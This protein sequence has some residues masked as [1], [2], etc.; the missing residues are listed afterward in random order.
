VHQGGHRHRGAARVAVLAAMALLTVAI[1]GPASALAAPS[2]VLAWGFNG[3]GQLGDGAI[4]GPEE[5]PLSIFGSGFERAPC[6]RI[7]VPVSG[8]SG[9]TSIAAAGPGEHGVHGHSLALLSN[10]TVVAWGSNV[11]GELGDGVEGEP[12]DVPVP[13]SGLSGV[14]A[15][16]AGEGHSL[17]LLSDGTVAAWGEN[18]AGQLGDGSRGEPSDVPV[19]V[20]GLSGVTAVAAGERDSLALLSDGTV[21][22]WGENQ[23]GELGDG[24][25]GEP[26][27]V[28]VPVSG[29]SGVTAIAAGGRSNLAL[30]GDGTV[31]AWGSGTDVPVPVSGLTGVT[32]IASGGDFCLA[33][34]SNGTVMAWGENIGGAL[35]DGG[36][37]NENAVV[38]VQVSGLT[39]VMAV[40]AG[41]HDGLA[42]L[43]N[44]TVMAW[45]ENEFGQLGDG[46]TTRS[47]VPVPVSSLGGATA[48][49]DAGEHSL[50]VSAL[51]SVTAV[52]PNA[53]PFTGGTPVSITGTNFTGATAVRFG[54]ASAVRITLHSA[55]SITA[56]SPPGKGTVDVTVTS[57]AG[58]SPTRVADRF[59]YEP[60]V[61]GVQPNN[62]PTN[63]RPVVTITGKDLAGATAVRFGSANAVG[64]RVTSASSIAAVPPAGTGTVNVTVT[65]PGGTSALSTAD[66]F[67]Y[68]TPREW[69]IFPTPSLG[70][71]EN[72]LA[73]ISCVSVRFCVAVGHSGVGTAETLIEVWNGSAWSTGAAPPTPTFMSATEL[74]AVSCV[75]VNFCVAVGT[76]RDQG[77][78]PDSSGPRAL[79][80][81]WNGTTWS[82]HVGAIKGEPEDDR[83]TLNGVS[84]VSSSFCLAV[85]SFGNGPLETA[86]GSW[87][88]E[89]WKYLP[90]PRTLGFPN[91]ELTSVSCVSPT[92][93]MAV[94]WADEG[95]KGVRTPVTQSWNGSEVSVVPSPMRGSG[96]D[97]LNG[98]S[99]V[100]AEDCVAVGVAE[101]PLIENWNGST[102]SIAK[103]S[104]PQGMEANAVSCVSAGSCT[105]VG[106]DVPSEKA[107]SQTLVG[108]SKGGVWSIVSSANG[109][110]GASAL[111]GVSC[112]PAAPGWKPCFAVG[113]DE[114]SA[115]GPLQALVELG[116]I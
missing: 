43:S 66:Q 10:G 90:R 93:C 21:V 77:A 52:Q 14:T 23:A 72:R 54:S 60:V 100:S 24:V 75:S 110:A 58:T 9:V 108:V 70:A 51:P 104:H 114:A 71:V 113:S 76:W 116:E 16:A 87:N 34:L 95:F 99:C 109:A 30:L 57:G 45:G 101:G 79:I 41:G 68:A 92:F 94:G 98:V 27:D 31:V 33:L 111:N 65:S 38:P 32:A 59:S 64:F 97:V 47:N 40:A 25:K 42:L 2:S 81:V 73:G 36:S 96:P 6:S 39:R 28:P 86:V 5:C 106:T 83:V 61:T 85:G 49:A 17:A 69:T 67:T 12:S 53:G 103:G 91:D 102:W 82:Q 46:T 15:I 63:G 48:I 80:D 37:F 29:L 107:P 13:V 74:R 115:E 105:A 88:G 55:T 22:A 26:S 62:G 8:L 50:A 20:S 35:G 18:G 7:P 56:V 3:Q 4:T 78:S 84:C 112:V 89:T 1:S 11:S 19:P 44:G